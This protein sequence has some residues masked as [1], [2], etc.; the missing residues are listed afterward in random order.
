MGMFEQLFSQMCLQSSPVGGCTTSLSCE[1]TSIQ[2][3]NL[4]LNAVKTVEMIVNSRR[5]PAPTILC[6]SP[7][8]HLLVPKVVAKHQL[9]HQK[10]KAEYVLP[11]AAEGTQFTKSVTVYFYSSII[12]S[13]LNSSIIIWYTA[14]TVKDKGRLQGVSHS[15]DKAIGYNMPTLQ[16]LYTSRTLRWAGKIAFDPIALCPSLDINFM[17]HSSLAGG[18]S[19]SGPLPRGI[20]TISF[21][22]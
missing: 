21:P 12:E 15:A 18:Y 5:I 22:I 7:L 14:A 3:E 17:S 20:T 1:T 9:P 4:D 8:P 11:V 19:S 13:I 6:N 10:S 2:V 16:D